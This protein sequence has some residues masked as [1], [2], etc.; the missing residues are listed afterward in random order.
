[1]GRKRYLDPV[2]DIEPLGMVIELLGDER[3]ARHEAEGFV[4][5]LEREF[6][7]DRV[8][9]ID[10]GPTLELGEGRLARRASQFFSHVETLHS[11]HAGSRSV[12]DSPT[13]R[14]LVRTL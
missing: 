4:E 10:F 13:R 9:A 7:A 12:A 5:V 11:C 2:V 1:M 6:P 8:A 14:S 3:R